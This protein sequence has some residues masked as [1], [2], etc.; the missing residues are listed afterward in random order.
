MARRPTITDQVNA[1]IAAGAY[2]HLS[3]YANGRYS[4]A[5]AVEYLVNLY[6]S[7]G[8]FTAAAAEQVIAAFDAG[9]YDTSFTVGSEDLSG[10]LAPT[11]GAIASG[12]AGSYQYDVSIEI[13]CYGQRDYVFTRIVSDSLL[14][15]DELYGQAL[16]AAMERL[17]SKNYGGTAAEENCEP[18]GNFILHSIYSLS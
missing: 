14:S 12:E 2:S 18:T 10:L 4:Y 1:A 13:E 9:R 8:T 17:T 15:G 6:G 5:E 16:D 3:A 7:M 11:E